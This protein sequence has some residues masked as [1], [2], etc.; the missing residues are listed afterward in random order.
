MLTSPS[1]VDAAWE[2]V[3]KFEWGI[4][5]ARLE[6]AG[7]PRWRIDEVQWH[8]FSWE[9]KSEAV[10]CGNE[11]DKACYSKGGLDHS[12]IRWWH[13][14]WDTA[15]RHEIGHGIL[16]KLGYDCWKDWEHV[17]EEGNPRNGGC[18]R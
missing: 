2:E 1:P 16:D 18:P 14:K 9:P 15:L 13:P 3:V 17:D 12:I 10:Q 8:D 5:V 7:V 4:A 11:K 6:A